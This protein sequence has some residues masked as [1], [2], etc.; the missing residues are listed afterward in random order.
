M[1]SRYITVTTVRIIEETP[2]SAGASWDP[3]SYQPGPPPQP[4]PGTNPPQFT[5]PGPGTG[6]PPSPPAGAAGQT[7]TITFQNRPPSKLDAG[8]VAFFY[9]FFNSET[10]NFENNIMEVHLSGAMQPVFIAS[11][12]SNFASQLY[13]T[14]LETTTATEM[15]QVR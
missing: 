1:I 7:P 14:P 10:N 9:P 3:S 2:G 13:D 4:I 12:A 6:E 8:K 11:T 5:Q 15:R